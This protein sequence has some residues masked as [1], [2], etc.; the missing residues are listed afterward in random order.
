MTTQ[1][2]PKS[3]RTTAQ[4][5]VTMCVCIHV[6]TRTERTS[7][8]QFVVFTNTQMHQPPPSVHPISQIHNWRSIMPEFICMVPAE[9]FTRCLWVSLTWLG[10]RSANLL[11][12][13]SGY[14]SIIGW[15]Q[16]TLRI[17]W[18]WKLMSVMGMVLMSPCFPRRM[19]NS[20]DIFIVVRDVSEDFTTRLIYCDTSEDMRYTLKRHTQVLKL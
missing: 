4:C 5:T 8:R 15:I 7:C 11:G 16:E 1:T 17:W 19:W 10:C 12:W 20:S 6:R 3:V 14:S 2:H 18:F 13:S 9:V